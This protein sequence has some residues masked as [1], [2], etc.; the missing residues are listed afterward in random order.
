MTTTVHL[1]T[2]LTHLDPADAQ[3]WRDWFVH[4]G[5]D[6]WD[7][8][9]LPSE[10]TWMPRIKMLKVQVQRYDDQRMPYTIAVK[11]KVPGELWPFPG[12]YRVDHG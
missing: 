8:I 11:I 2:R 9:F 3:A 7:Q 1:N 5:I 10:L 4:H 12:G 6:E